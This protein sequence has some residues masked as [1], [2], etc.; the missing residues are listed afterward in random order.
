MGNV[1]SRPIHRDRE[2]V[3]VV[4]GWEGVT[5]NRDRASFGGWNVLELV[6]MTTHTCEHTK[7]PLNT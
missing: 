3:P 7:K 4:R 2:W 1:Q 5:A 6:V